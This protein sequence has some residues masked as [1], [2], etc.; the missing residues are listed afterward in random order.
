MIEEHAQVIEIK[1]DSVLLQAQTQS[2]CGSCAAN[3]GCGTSVLAKVVGRKFTR[4]QA[5]NNIDVKVG[6][7]VVVGIA[8]DALLKGS[9]VMYIIPVVGMFLFALLADQ[10]YTA[11]FYERD[12]MVAAAAIAGLIAG[13]LCSRWYFKRPASRQ[14]FSP[15]ILRKIIEHGKL[16]R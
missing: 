5:E 16:A 11:T 12:L 14:L 15:V 10:F 3:K 4:F 8:E 2:A 13:S 1:G 6:D 7:T 9:L